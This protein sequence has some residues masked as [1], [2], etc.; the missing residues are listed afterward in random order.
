MEAVNAVPPMLSHKPESVENKDFYKET[1]TKDSKAP[2]KCILIQDKI[3]LLMSKLDL[4]G[5][6]SCSP[7][8]QKEVKDLIIEYGSL[9]K[10]SGFR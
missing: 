1:E 9:F 5:I 10:G 3:D 4:E 7:D 2:E 8:E 6:K